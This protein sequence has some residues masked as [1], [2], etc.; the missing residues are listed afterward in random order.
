L[1][2]AFLAPFGG[3]GGLGTTYTA[4]LSLIRK[5]VVDFLFVLIDF[6]FARCYAE[7]L[8]ANTD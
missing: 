8:R 5:L 6:F 3:G 1:N 2:T 4:H 7:S